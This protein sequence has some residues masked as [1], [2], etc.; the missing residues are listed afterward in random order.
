MARRQSLPVRH[1]DP[2]AVAVASVGGSLAHAGLA[3]SALP[4]LLESE[5]RNRHDAATWLDLLQ[6]DAGSPP[7]DVHV[8]RAW[9]TWTWAVGVVMSTIAIAGGIVLAV[10]PSQ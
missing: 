2:Q 5:R 3:V 8:R 6:P 10:V 4:R 7:G 1:R 9:P